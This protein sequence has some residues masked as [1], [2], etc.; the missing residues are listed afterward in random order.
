M[1]DVRSQMEGARRD[2]RHGRVSSEEAEALTRSYV[3]PLAKS[4]FDR[5]LLGQETFWTALYQPL[6]LRDVTRETVRDRGP[7]GA[8]RTRGNY[9]TVLQMFNLP[10][11]DY[12]RFLSFLQKYE[13]HVPFQ[14]FRAVRR[15]RTAPPCV[16]RTPS[17]LR[18]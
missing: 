13:C 6:M 1:A 17:R 7:D 5:M 9:R 12:K 18:V 16:A 8:D 2:G 10:P 15:C 4:Y 14:A 3:D 11:T